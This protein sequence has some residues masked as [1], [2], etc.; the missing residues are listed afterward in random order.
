MP[1]MKGKAG[2]PNASR[3]PG[4]E[5]PYKDA[6]KV[7]GGPVENQ[8]ESGLK[9]E[10]GVKGSGKTPAGSGNRPGRKARGS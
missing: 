6:A 4:G 8:L 9:P 3:K 7:V 2:K 10:K 5:L 1:G